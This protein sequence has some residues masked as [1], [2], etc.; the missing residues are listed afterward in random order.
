VSQQSNLRDAIPGE[1]G[2]LALL[3][4]CSE[5]TK[6]TTIMEALSG[7]LNGFQI[8]FHP[9]NIFVCFV[10]CVLGTLVGVLPGIGPTSAISLLLPITFRADPVSAIIMLAGIYYGA[11]YGGSTTSIL[12]N[13]PGEPSSVVTCFDGYPMAQQGRAG[14]ALGISAFGSFIAGTAAIF[15]LTFFAPV[16]SKVALRF[17]PA[18]NVGIMVLSL[19]L[20]AFLAQGSMVRALM[21]AALGLILGTVGTDLITGRSRFSYGIGTLAD[22]IGLIPF[23]VGM[24]GVPSLKDWK[25]S[26][27]PMI[28]ATVIGFFLGILPGV[29][30]I[31]PTFVSYSVEKRLSKYPEKFGTGIIEGVAGPET[32]NNA[33][34]GAA[35]IP[36][37]SLGIPPNAVMAVLLGALMIH[38]VQPGPQFIASHPDLFWGVVAS[39]YIGNVMLLILNLPLIPLWVQILKVPYS[40]LFSLI[41]LFCLIGTYTINNNSGDIMVMVLFGFVGYLVKKYRYE[42][43]PLILAF[44]LGPILEKNVRQA[45][46]ISRG[47][48][49]VFFTHPISM[50]FF[51]VAM[52]LLILPLFRKRRIGMGQAGTLPEDNA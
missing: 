10:G 28:R 8:V 9:V 11:M 45:L 40:L 19:T 50:A 36:M 7:L 43:S 33:A 1:T 39:M 27:L 34:A 29:G 48:F 21:M 32:A 26:T 41:L 49:A 37:F 18:E 25:A 3:A 44:V 17:G 20:L 14:P 6:S 4:A 52:L 47:S 51:A 46:I 13:I 22:G 30:A 2:A 15:G 42:V 35:F 38:G 12:V 23:V 16:L 5:E 24:F 31:I